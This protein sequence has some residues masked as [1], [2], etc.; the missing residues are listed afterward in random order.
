V[1]GTPTDAQ[2]LGDLLLAPVRQKK[3]KHLT[4]AGGE[5]LCFVAYAP[6]LQNLA[7]KSGTSGKDQ[8]KQIALASAKRRVTDG[9]VHADIGFTERRDSLGA[10]QHLGDM[11]GTQDFVH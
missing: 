2:P 7:V 1:R 5:S 11:T 10:N 8:L 4:L 9:A 3:T 6:G